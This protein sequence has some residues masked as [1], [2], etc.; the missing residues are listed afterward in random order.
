[1]VWDLVHFYSLWK[2]LLL[3]PVVCFGLFKMMVIPIHYTGIQKKKNE[4]MLQVWS[5]EWTGE[6]WV[7]SSHLHFCC[8][9]RSVT[10]FSVAL[11]L[12]TSLTNQ[13][14]HLS[15]LQHSLAFLKTGTIYQNDYQ[16]SQKIKVFF[17]WCMVLILASVGMHV[18]VCVCVCVLPSIVFPMM[19]SQI[20]RV[21]TSKLTPHPATL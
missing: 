7:A 10:N 11:P 16:C 17:S 6:K 15:N 8:T 20:K 2:L 5:T 1:M 4:Q 14:S 19:K 18:C 12:W 13:S 9:G 21:P 3:A